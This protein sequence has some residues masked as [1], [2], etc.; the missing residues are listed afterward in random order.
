MHAELESALAEFA[1]AEPADQI[2][3]LRLRREAEERL[4]PAFDIKGFHDTM[5]S[6]GAMPLPMLREV[7]ESWISSIAV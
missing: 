6:N 7:V 2:E 3:I 1:I 5:L 4:G